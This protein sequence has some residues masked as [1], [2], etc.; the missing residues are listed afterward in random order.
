MKKVLLANSI[1]PYETG[2]G[3]DVNDL[4]AARLTRGQ[5][6]YTAKSIFPAFALHLLAENLN[7]HTTIME[8]PTEALFRKELEKEYDYLGIQ[9]KSIHMSQIARMVKI[10]REVSP[11]TEIVLGGYGVMHIFQ[12]YPNDPLEDAKYLRENADH[13]C[14]EEGVGFFRKII[15]QNP[16]DRITQVKQP[17]FEVTVHGADYLARFPLSSTLVSL[18]CPNA[19]EFC[20]TSH[21]FKFKKITI[22]TPE[23][24]FASLKAANDR[25]AGLPS[26]FNMIWDEDFLIDRDYVMRLGELLQK[27]GLI[28]KVNLFC[29]ASIRSI[30][31]FT[32]EELVRCGIGALWI[33]VE[34]KFEDGILSEH[35]FQKRVGRNVVEVFEELHNHG[36]LIIGSNILGLDFHNHQNILEDIDYFVSLKPDLYQVSPLRPCPGT[37]LYDRLLEDGRIEE[38]FRAQDTMLWSDIGLKHPNFKRGEIQKYFHLEHKKLLET[39]GPTVLS[40]MDVML[41]GY[42]NMVHSPDPFL[43]AK[44]DRC[45]FFAKKLGAGFLP[46]VREMIPTPAVRQRVDEVE[47]Q[48]RRHIGDF[49]AREK[50]VQQ[51][52]RK[53]M[54]KQAAKEPPESYTPDYLIT[55]VKGPGA[56]PKVVKRQRPLRHLLSQGSL[57]VLRKVLDLQHKNTVPIRLKDIDDFP[58]EFQTMEIEGN[59]MNYVDE[60]KGEVLLMLHGNPA[61]SYLYRHFIKD[62]KKDY[63]CIALDHLG[64]GLSDKPHFEDYSMEAHIR[65]LGVFIDKMGL[66]NITL[67]CQ[68]WGGIIGLSYAA[69]NK[70]LFSR[71]IPMN[72][73]GFLPKSP[74]EFAR[75]IGAWAFPYLWSYKVPV[76]GKKMAMD[77]NIFLRAGMHLG[78]YNSKRQLHPKAINGYLYPFQ[79]VRDRTA[80]MKSVRQVPM[81]PLDKT[82]WLLRD[83]GKALEGWDVRTQVIWGMK[84]PVFVPWFMEKFETLLPNHAPSMKIP[85][86]G[87]FLQDDEPEIIIKA[88]RGFLSEKQLKRKKNQSKQRAA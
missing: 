82:W 42:R 72:T 17:M 69:R 36:I 45:Y 37:T 41:R 75:C 6:P 32:V 87:H 81:G 1:G 84:D 12:P 86:A 50:I 76:L 40:V 55:Q 7:A 62:L 27:G 4:F 65:R 35:N 44:A 31:Q 33:G 24:T 28:G 11:L 57:K 53:M 80:I 79:M 59:R 22:C 26:L 85:T 46:S 56:G 43:Q 10:A 47:K 29:F 25:M 21:F 5:G 58:V 13:F 54:K 48:Y 15:G 74:G 23:E 83:T 88:I 68:D 8:W 18:G 30:S 38:E 70:E 14:F 73:T 67:I 20:N 64:Y 51:A 16:K 61:W 78:I 19:C 63:R 9:V 49:S 77:W 2:W 60:G 71:L 39:N 34:S 66:K 3:E 52:I